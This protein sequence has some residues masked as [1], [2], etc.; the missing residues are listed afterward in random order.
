MVEDLSL[1][2]SDGPGDLGTLAQ[3]ARDQRA[4]EPELYL[5]SAHGCEACGDVAWGFGVDGELCSC[6]QGRLVYLDLD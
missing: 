3:L 4:K 6:G 2:D 1:L 5:Y